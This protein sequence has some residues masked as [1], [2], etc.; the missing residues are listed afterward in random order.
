MKVID[1]NIPKMS[2]SP[3]AEAPLQNNS[4]KLF[5]RIDIKCSGAY[6]FVVSGIVIPRGRKNRENFLGELAE[7][8]WNKKVFCVH[9]LYARMHA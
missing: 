4:Q 9:F 7:Y 2:L 5:S 1:E 6:T 3:I 8:L